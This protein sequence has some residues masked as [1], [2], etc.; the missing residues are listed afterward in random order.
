[1][2]IAITADW[3]LSGKDLAEA[4]AQLGAFVAE[5]VA[6]KVELVAVAGDVFDESTIHDSRAGTGAVGKVLTA[7]LTALDKANIP[8]VMI[9]GNH[10]ASGA[11]QADALHVLDGRPM[12]TILRGGGGFAVADFGAVEIIGVPWRWADPADAEPTIARAI[13]ER[14]DWGNVSA[15]TLFL[16][17]IQIVGGRMAGSHTCSTRGEWRASRACLDALD[18][19]HIALGD[20]HARQDLT[21]GRGG[22]VGALRQLNFGEEGNPAGFEVW[23]SESGAVEWVELDAA[24]RYRTVEVGPGDLDYL[25]PEAGE[26]ERLR[27]RYVGHDTFPM[28]DIKRLEADGVQVEQIVERKERV[29]RAE[30]REGVVDSPHGLIDLWAENLNKAV[31]VPRMHRVFDLVTADSTAVAETEIEGVLL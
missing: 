6:R 1:M 28:E 13:S 25:P 18:V 31:D 14:P 3:H 9:A 23:D 17:H 22:Y 30:V 26:N 27:V 11:G 20:F 16:S 24:P 8:Q 21:G 10:D 29:R 4:S 7:T 12:L 19:D 5:C 2:K 15:A